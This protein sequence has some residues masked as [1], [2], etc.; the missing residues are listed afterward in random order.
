MAQHHMTLDDEEYD[1]IVTHR[2]AL[3]KEPMTDMQWAQAIIMHLTGKPDDPTP[4]LLQMI[5]D[6]R[7]SGKD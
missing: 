2:K 6:I 3:E 7:V 5:A 4:V 1:L